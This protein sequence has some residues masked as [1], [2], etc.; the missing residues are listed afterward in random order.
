MLKTWN[1]SIRLG[2]YSATVPIE[3]E[4]AQAAHRKAMDQLN[5]IA[6]DAQA[7]ADEKRRQKIADRAELFK[8]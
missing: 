7:L 3:A 5:L 8:R 4:T 1:I 2:A 6:V